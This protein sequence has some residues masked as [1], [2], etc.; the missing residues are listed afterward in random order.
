[1]NRIFV[2]RRLNGRGPQV[3]TPE[4]RRSRAGLEPINVDEVTAKDG[5]HRDSMTDEARKDY[6][7]TA[8]LVTRLKRAF[9]R[10]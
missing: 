1:M 2:F 5:G 9:A 6:Y 3:L 7:L 4:Q 10:Q 8:T